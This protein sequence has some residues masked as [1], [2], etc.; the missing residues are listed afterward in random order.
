MLFLVRCPIGIDCILDLMFPAHL[1]LGCNYAEFPYFYL[2]P[3]AGQCADLATST[4]H[5]C[6]SQPWYE[7]F[8]MSAYFISP[9]SRKKRVYSSFTRSLRVQWKIVSVVLCNFKAEHVWQQQG[10]LNLVS[11]IMVLYLW[12][13]IF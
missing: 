4:K 13:G 7:Y 9:L 11:S 2:K 3:P 5:F 6:L 1:S 12:N 10:P 8:F